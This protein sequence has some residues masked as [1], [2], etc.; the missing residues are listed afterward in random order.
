MAGLHAFLTTDPAPSEL[1]YA[2]LAGF[3]GLLI[4]TTLT[5]VSHSLEG[6]FE[7]VPHNSASIAP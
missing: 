2:F 5:V 4:I 3:F 7:G 1:E 6:Y